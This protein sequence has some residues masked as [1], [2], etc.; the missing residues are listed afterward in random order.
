ME[1]A[2]LQAKVAFAALNKATNGE[3][4]EKAATT[5]KAPEP[6]AD[7][8]GPPGADT[9]KRG[10]PMSAME[11][12]DHEGSDQEPEKEMTFEEMMDH[13]LELERKEREEKNGGAAESE[14]SPSAEHKD[15]KEKGEGDAPPEDWEV[16]RAVKDKDHEDIEFLKDDGANMNCRDAEGFT[17]LLRAADSNQPLVV[18]ALLK[19]GADPNLRNEDGTLWTALH[20]GALNGFPKVVEVLLKYKADRTVLDSRGE[21]ALQWAQANK[22]E[23]CIKLLE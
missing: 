19:C 12:S 16:F 7:R 10:L 22:E 6:A 3:A 4:N 23:A 21:T 13:A 14:A 11:D 17:P 20:I 5:T 15:H 18:E 9:L 1:A 2:R 8:R